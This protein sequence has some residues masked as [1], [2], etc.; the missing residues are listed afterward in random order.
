MKRE[1]S[2]LGYPVRDRAWS[3]RSSGMV[4]S[5]GRPFPNRCDL[6][7]TSD[8]CSASAIQWMTLRAMKR[9]TLE[10]A[11]DR[12]GLMPAT[13]VRKAPEEA[14]ALPNANRDGGIP[15]SLPNAPRDNQ[16]ILNPGRNRQRKK[17]YEFSIV[18][19]SDA[20]IV[21]ASHR[22]DLCGMR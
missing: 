2:G 1:R 3:T 16:V 11:A 4:V 13:A 19:E 18:Q 12:G 7:G 6:N 15:V 20:V 22:L 17:N 21:L 5:A 10:Y 8:G 14:R 9:G